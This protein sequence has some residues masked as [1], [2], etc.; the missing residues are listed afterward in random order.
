MKKIRMSPNRIEIS[1]IRSYVTP[2]SAENGDFAGHEDISREI[3]TDVTA[4][5]FEIA[6][7]IRDGG[8]SVLESGDFFGM[9]NDT[10]TNFD[11]TSE[12]DYLSISLGKNIDQGAAIDSLQALVK[13]YLIIQ[14]GWAEDRANRCVY[15]RH[16]PAASGL[17]LVK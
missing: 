7:Q 11:G 10:Y 2:E 8:F 15:G 17:Q 16:A 12:R 6:R 1:V 4:A 5:A 3:Y 14:F 9:Y 13:H